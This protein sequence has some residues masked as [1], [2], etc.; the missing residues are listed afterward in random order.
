MNYLELAQIVLFGSLVG[1][2][3][4]EIKYHFYDKK[5][6]FIEIPS[7]TIEDIRL[8]YNSNLPEEEIINLYSNLT[9][10]IYLKDHVGATTKEDLLLRDNIEKNL[11]SVISN[12]VNE[13]LKEGKKINP[14]MDLNDIS[15]TYNKLTLNKN[16]KL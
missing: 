2:S 1:L 10:C 5:K 13:Y 12:E 11:E 9:N 7:K 15:R 16:Y 4:I 14:K 8:N 3:S 6:K